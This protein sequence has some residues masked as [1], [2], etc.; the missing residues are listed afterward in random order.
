MRSAQFLAA[1]LLF[2]NLQ[3]PV[4]A[5][6]SGTIGFQ[7]LLDSAM[8][9]GHQAV[10]VKSAYLRAKAQAQPMSNP[11]LT[12]EVRPEVNG[13]A[14]KTQEYE[15]GLEQDLKLGDFSQRGK[16][17]DLIRKLAGVEQQAA[18]LEVRQTLRQ[19]Y[20][21][22]WIVQRRSS[23]LRS[24]S[25][26]SRKINQQVNK[27]A[28]QGLYSK[29]SKALS[30]VGL[31]RIEQ[32]SLSNR[33]S[34]LQLLKE[35]N[36]AA[37]KDVSKLQL[38]ALDLGELPAGEASDFDLR[39]LPAQQRARLK[40]SLANEQLRLA[41]LDAYPA[42]TPRVAYERTD[43][44]IDR[45]NVGLAVDLPF[46]NRNQSAVYEARAGA[47]EADF[48]KRYQDSSLL[49]QDFNLLLETARLNQKQLDAYDKVILPQL[50][51]ALKAVE[52]EVTAGQADPQV[53][54]TVLRE[55]AE[56]EETYLRVFQS[57][58]LSRSEI[59]I[60]LGREL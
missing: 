8:L 58:L 21:R 50:Q 28:G 12:A 16:V 25:E 40:V 24:L 18:F 38:T 59:E 43:D 45:V 11:R 34:E 49:D 15:I 48:V 44:G 37:F 60:F 19:L 2:L 55:V 20:V 46:F 56:G 35:L 29:S 5:E 39:N 41:R 6:Q 26:Y 32:E 14:D 7:E 4:L 3:A 10:A 31:A 27:A 30:D 36:Q 1:F 57:A 47:L 54:W 9:N 23:Y 42:F 52:S 33:A 17:A 13:V 22:T 53:V 51:A